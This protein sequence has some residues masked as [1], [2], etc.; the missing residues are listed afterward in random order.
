VQLK[1]GPSCGALKYPAKQ[2]HI[3]TANPLVVVLAGHGRQ[4]SAGSECER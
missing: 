3:A 4:E 2:G 1:L